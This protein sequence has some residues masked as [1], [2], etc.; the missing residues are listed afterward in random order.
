M[1]SGQRGCGVMR[2]LSQFVCRLFFSAAHPNHEASQNAIQ[3]RPTK[4]TL[5]AVLLAPGENYA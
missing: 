1:S 2:V 3:H 4:S 5:L